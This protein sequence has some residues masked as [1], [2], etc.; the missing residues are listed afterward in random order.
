MPRHD[1]RV[2]YGKGAQTLRLVPIDQQGRPRV[3]TAATYAL[4]DL[5]LSETSDDREVVAAGTAATV[6]SVSTT[7]TAAAGY[8]AANPRLV[9]LTSLT[10]VAVGRRYLLRGTTGG[11]ELVTV[12]EIVSGGVLVESQITA[13]FATGS[14]FLGLE[15]AVVFPADEANDE[16]EVEAGGGP[17]A[18]DLAF[19]GITPAYQRFLCWIDRTTSQVLATVAD[20]LE[21]EQTVGAVAGKRMSI[22]AAISRAAKDMQTEQL[23]AGVDASRFLL[24]E[25][26]RDYQTYRAAGLLLQHGDERAQA[27]GVERMAHAQ[28]LLNAVIQG[29]PEGVASPNRSG[30]EAA[31][32]KSMEPRSYFRRT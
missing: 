30:D 5:R 18:F 4:V 28:R 2:L 31:P 11:E 17:Y 6:D 8:G 16:D 12:A 24:G 25:V 21:L 20:V 10:G 7:T 27:R 26:G 3:C 19:T 29:R 32:G 14:A 22:P 1:L 23:V 13:A 9:S 15:V